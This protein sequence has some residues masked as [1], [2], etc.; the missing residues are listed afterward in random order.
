MKYF[1]LSDSWTTGRVWEFGGL[2]NELAWHREPYLKQRS[3]CIKENDETL[4]LYEAE[5]AIL[6]VEVMPKDISQPTIGQVRLKRLLSAEQ[7]ITRLCQEDQ[8]FQRNQ[9]MPTTALQSSSPENRLVM[10]PTVNVSKAIEENGVNRHNLTSEEQD[11]SRRSVMP[12][13]QPQV[14]QVTC[15]EEAGTPQTMTT[16]SEP[17]AIN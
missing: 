12:A 14:A 5:D 17:T 13:G 7:A 15:Q 3:L 10:A 11:S 8:I 2:W 6:M 16:N 1:F 9:G 4:H